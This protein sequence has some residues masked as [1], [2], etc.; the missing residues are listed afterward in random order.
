MNNTSNDVI[1]DGLV[2]SDEMNVVEDWADCQWA[3]LAVI[4]LS[5]YSYIFCIQFFCIEQQINLALIVILYPAMR[6]L[7]FM[8]G[9]LFYADK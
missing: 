4:K 5:I 6:L 2:I 8:Y 3:L 1:I 9:I 7:K